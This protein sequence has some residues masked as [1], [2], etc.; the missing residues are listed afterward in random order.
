[1]HD[2]RWEGMGM[3]HGERNK[4]WAKTRILLAVKVILLHLILAVCRPMHTFRVGWS[5][6]FLRGLEKQQSQLTNCR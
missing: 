2:K 3:M 1:M 4:E 6:R 5:P